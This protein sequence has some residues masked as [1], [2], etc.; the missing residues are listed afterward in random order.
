MLPVDDNGKSAIYAHLNGLYF[1]ENHS[2][3]LR[4]LSKRIPF[5]LES[6][7]YKTKRKTFFNLITFC[8]KYVGAI[9]FVV[10]DSARVAHFTRLCLKAVT[11]PNSAEPTELHCFNLLIIGMRFSIYPFK[12]LANISVSL[13]SLPVRH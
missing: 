10:S 11:E 7:V 4:V 3:F 2:S 5:Y 13:K 9:C 6:H 8:L 12:F 1:R